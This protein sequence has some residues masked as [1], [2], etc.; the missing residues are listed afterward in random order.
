MFCTFKILGFWPI[1]VEVP[2]YR[3]AKKT[4]M[5][6]A[7]LN[8]LKSIILSVLKQIKTILY[9]YK[10][11]FYFILTLRYKPFKGISELQN[12]PYPIKLLMP[13]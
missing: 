6:N 1:A 8:G 11:E 5:Y 13:L 7:A 4:I 10:I 3:I 9:T 2:S 12:L